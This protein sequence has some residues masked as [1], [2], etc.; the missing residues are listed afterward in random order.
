MG[1]SELCTLAVST[2]DPIAAEGLQIVPQLTQ[3]R[4][5]EKH[6]PVTADEGLWLQLTRLTKLT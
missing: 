3:L 1:L 2:K 6:L 4:Q 5:L